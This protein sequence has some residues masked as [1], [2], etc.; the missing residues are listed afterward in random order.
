MTA[1][2]KPGSPMNALPAKRRRTH[3]VEH[4]RVAHRHACQRAGGHAGRR[5]LD[6]ARDRKACRPLA[7]GVG[8]IDPAARDRRL[9]ASAAAIRTPTT[10]SRRNKTDA[11]SRSRPPSRG[12][13]RPSCRLPPMRSNT[14]ASTPTRTPRPAGPIDRA[15]E[16]TAPPPST[17][18]TRRAA[19]DDSTLTRPRPAPKLTASSAASIR[20]GSES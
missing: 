5:D 17:A 16:N 10:V 4:H 19:N 7:P 9:A 18:S 13:E 12:T 11:R 2:A 1:D 20:S 3:A 14:G 8:A 6:T 15:V